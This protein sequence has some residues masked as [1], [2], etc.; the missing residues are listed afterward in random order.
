VQTQAEGAQRRLT[1]QGE[2]FDQP[3]LVAGAGAQ[4]DRAA[5]QLL[6]VELL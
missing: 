4:R 1:R 6:I 3:M 5:T 2:G